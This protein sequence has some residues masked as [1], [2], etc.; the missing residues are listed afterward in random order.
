MVLREIKSDVSIQ[1]LWA[2]A[3]NYQTRW[4]SC[5]IQNNFGGTNRIWVTAEHNCL[6]ETDRQELKNL[7]E[8]RRPWIV[9][10]SYTEYH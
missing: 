3:A 6:Y 2:A 9:F 5:C 10:H 1:T 4:T 7:A 8:P